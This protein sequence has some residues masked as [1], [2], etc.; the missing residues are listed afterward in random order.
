M[1]SVRKARRADGRATQ[2]R[3]LDS[4]EAAFATGPYDGISLRKITSEA[5]VNLALV[6]YHFH[7]KESLYAAVVTR[8]ATVLRARRIE[9]LEALPTDRAPEVGAVLDAFMRP[10]LER[11]LSGDPGWFSYLR[12]LGFIGTE[13]R[14]DGL[15]AELFDPTARV[16]YTA[17][18]DALPGAAPGD[19]AHGLSFVILL[20]LRALAQ[21]GR[22]PML[23]EDPSA[24]DDLM[25]VYE[26]LLPF[27]EAGLIRIARPG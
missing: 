26:R 20:M 23:L 13:T 19:V 22:A 8:R 11:V 27:C 21:E 18:Q 12:I 4:A 3:I 6:K 2:A 9:M 5:D 25:A 7:S 17:L 14:F 10:L 1:Q 24:N 16:F 15:A